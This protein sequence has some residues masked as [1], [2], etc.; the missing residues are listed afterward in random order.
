MNQKKIII[1]AASSVLL[2][3]LLFT[4][5]FAPDTAKRQPQEMASVETVETA[6]LPSVKPSALPSVSPAE[7]GV[8]AKEAE[9]VETP[10]PSGTR[11]PQDKDENKAQ[12]NSGHVETRIESNVPQ[13]LGA[14]PV[15]PEQAQEQ[16]SA[17]TSAEAP[18]PTPAPTPEPTP[19]PTPQSTPPP[20]AKCN[21]CGEMVPDSELYEHMKYHALHDGGGGWS[22][23]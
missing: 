14:E 10:K 8:P 22:T 2:G 12:E 3:A 15:Q 16:V 18:A 17:P 20:G 6:A 19:V 11:Q 7:N 21:V 5:C 1:T 23:E 13:E 4:G 9:A